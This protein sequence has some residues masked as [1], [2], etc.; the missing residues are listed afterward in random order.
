MGTNYIS[1]LSLQTNCPKF[2][3][4]KI[5]IND[6][7]IIKMIED[8]TDLYLIKL[9]Q[10]NKKDIQDKIDLNKLYQDKKKKM[11]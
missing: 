10:D 8:K 11:I 2:Q 3:L 7:K 9:Y 4:Q 6:S 1:Y 5:D